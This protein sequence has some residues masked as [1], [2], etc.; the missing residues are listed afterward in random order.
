MKRN[1]L[2]YFLVEGET[3]DV[4]IKDL[5]RKYNFTVK[6]IRIINLWNTAERKIK[7]LLNTL[8]LKNSHVFIVY[9]TDRVENINN[10]INNINIIS[11]CS[12]KT[13]IL[14][15][16]NNFEEEL[17]YACSKSTSALYS[18]FCVQITSC[19]NFKNSFISS[20]NRLEKLDGLNFNDDRLW[21]TARNLLSHIESQGSSKLKHFSFEE[22]KNNYTG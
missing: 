4:L 16:N 6:A 11:K 10:F 12:S 9:D 19:D 13:F 18:C 3:E 15:Q 22:F 8:E 7:A 14:Q 1:S 20:R 5:K 17:A 21:D 2:V